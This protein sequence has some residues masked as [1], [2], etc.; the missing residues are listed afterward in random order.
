MSGED[1]KKSKAIS[2]P[3]PIPTKEWFADVKSAEK[4]NTRFNDRIS[5]RW[6]SYLITLKEGIGEYDADTYCKMIISRVA[7]AKG[8]H[9]SDVTLRYRRAE[10]PKTDKNKL[11]ALLSKYCFGYVNVLKD[12][13]YTY[14]AGMLLNMS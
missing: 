1:N 6:P 2:G 3:P 8:C 10:A 12:S 9:E 11:P 13:I 14:I 4:G 5:F 7:E